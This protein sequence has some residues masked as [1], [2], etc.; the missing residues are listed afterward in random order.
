MTKVKLTPHFDEYLRE[1]VESGR[2]SYVSEV[3]RDALRLHERREAALA[4]AVATLKAEVRV[5]MDDIEAGRLH[6]VH[7]LAHFT[8]LT[9]P[10]MRATPVLNFP[11]PPGGT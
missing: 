3:V 8:A 4:A 9:E 6:P 1:A 7:D 11:N 2:Y 10:D 5:G